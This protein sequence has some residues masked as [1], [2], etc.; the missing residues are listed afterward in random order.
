[1]RRVITGEETMTERQLKRLKKY[2]GEEV[3]LWNL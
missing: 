3:I 1:M 2:L